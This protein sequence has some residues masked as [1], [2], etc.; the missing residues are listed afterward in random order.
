MSSFP[1]HGRQ[2]IKK[3]LDTIREALSV[4][5][6]K[7]CEKSSS[8]CKVEKQPSKQEEGNCHPNQHYGTLHVILVRKRAFSVS[9]FPLDVIQIKK[10][11]RE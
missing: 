4:N 6:Q 7:I 8:P 3:Q 9:S 5:P 2:N 11:S 10:G 1:G